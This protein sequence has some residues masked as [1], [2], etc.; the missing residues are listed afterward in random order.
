MK[1]THDP[2]RPSGYRAITLIL[3]MFP[4]P[5]PVKRDTL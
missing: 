2:S 3:N 4:K 1:Q 5:L